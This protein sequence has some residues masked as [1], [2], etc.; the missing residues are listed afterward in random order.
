LI[1]GMSLVVVLLCV[2][3]SVVC[4]VA[5]TVVIL[6]G[7]SNMV[8]N[9]HNAEL[10]SFL[11]QP[12]KDVRIAIRETHIFTNKTIG[13]LDF[14]W[15]F[16]RPGLGT[17]DMAFGPELPFGYF[18]NQK[19]NGSSPLIMLKCGF[20]GTNLYK[21]WHPK[22]GIKYSSCMQFVKSIGVPHTPSAL[23]WMQGESDAM[24]T[25]SQ[26]EE[27]EKLLPQL[28]ASMRSD[29]NAPNMKVI[30]P[31]INAAPSVAPYVAIVRAAEVKVANSTPNVVVFDTA[32]F[33]MYND[34]LHYV[35]GSL[36]QIGKLAT[37]FFFQ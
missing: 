22:N 21:D 29:L 7:Q 31:Q 36:I 15:G 13:E 2:L 23:L 5:P 11:S 8:G 6:A 1:M 9:G 19:L 32:G 14:P 26:A 34:H 3:V 28:I 37:Q 20:S 33:T 10:P 17:A 30:I 12:M 4:G 25:Q 18:V 16:L 27:Y 35:T 24:G